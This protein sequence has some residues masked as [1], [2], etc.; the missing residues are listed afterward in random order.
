MS[1]RKATRFAWALVHRDRC[2]LW[3]VGLAARRST[4]AAGSPETHSP[5][6]HLPDAASAMAF[7]AVGFLVATR[8]PDNPIGWLLL[9]P[10]PLFGLPMLAQAV[11]GV[12]P[13]RG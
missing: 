13:P 4:R 5:T 8:K 11:R 7:V 6:R 1:R 2:H 9:A 3:S 10:G 12:R